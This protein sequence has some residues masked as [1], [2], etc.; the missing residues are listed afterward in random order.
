MN[1]AAQAVDTFSTSEQETKG[2]TEL[3]DKATSKGA[4][5]RKERQEKTTMPFLQGC[6]ELSL[7]YARTYV[8]Q[9]RPALLARSE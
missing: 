7:T 9:E 1:E 5:E 8:L 6:V 3:Q 4:G 2:Q